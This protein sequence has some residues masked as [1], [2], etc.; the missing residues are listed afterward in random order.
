[1]KVIIKDMTIFTLKIKLVLS[2][3]TLKVDNGNIVELE[4][5]GREFETQ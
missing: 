5:E 1:M 2:Y 3:L 4:T